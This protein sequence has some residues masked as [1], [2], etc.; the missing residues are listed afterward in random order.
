MG[1]GFAAFFGLVIM[2]FGIYKMVECFKRKRTLNR[3][4][5]H[6]QLKDPGSGLP[7]DLNSSTFVVSQRHVTGLHPSASRKPPGRVTN[8]V[9]VQMQ[10]MNE[11]GSEE[12]FS[13]LNP[14]SQRGRGGGVAG[15]GA[16]AA[17]S[18]RSRTQVRVG[19]ESPDAV[20][21]QL[22]ASSVGSGR[23]SAQ[24]ADDD[25][26]DFVSAEEAQGPGTRECSNSIL[27]FG[28]THIPSSNS[29][30]GGGAVAANAHQPAFTGTRVAIGGSGQ[31]L[32]APPSSRSAG[33]AG[34]SKSVSPVAVGPS[35]DEASNAPASEGVALSPILRDNVSPEPPAVSLLAAAQVNAR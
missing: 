24:L 30:A 32:S 1:F 26:A 22:A 21:M 27:H 3:L 5:S 12:M 31:G 20:E 17:G 19:R 14:I 6:Y 4:Q 23:A 29:G 15:G 2:C 16:A 10:P 34:T 8:P 18:S 25:F 7:V 11:Q 33:V 9:S 28:G 13:S 35:R